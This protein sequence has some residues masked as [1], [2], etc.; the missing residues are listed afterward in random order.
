LLV[1]QLR[2]ASLLFKHTLLLQS[3]ILLTRPFLAILV[4]T[5]LLICAPVAL[6]VVV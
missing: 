3:V 1:A 5:L 6:L 2:A 4:S